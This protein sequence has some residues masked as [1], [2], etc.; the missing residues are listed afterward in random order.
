[1][2]KSNLIR[3]NGKR[4][5][6]GAED[7][8]Y[9]GLDVHKKS[10]NVAVRLGGQ[11]V[12]EWI[13]RSAPAAVISSLQP[14][15]KAAEKVV[16]EAGPCGYGLYRK[17]RE[18]RF[19]AEVWPPGK[20]P[21]K[22]NPGNKTDRLDASTLAE[23]GEKDL[24]E[25][26]VVPTRT[27]EAHR[28][29]MRTRNQIME[30]QKRV[31]QQIKSFLLMHGIEEPEGLKHWSKKG[32]RQLMELELTGELQMCLQMHLE[33]LAQVQHAKKQITDKL[34]CMSRSERYRQDFEN[35]TTHPGV[36]L[37]TA[38]NFILELY[39]PERFEVHRQVSTMLGLVPRFA[40]S[41]ERQTDKG[42]IGAGRESLRSMLVDAAW[43]WVGREQAASKTFGRLVGNTGCK[44]KGIVGIARKLCVN[45]W[46]MLTRR[47]PYRPGG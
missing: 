45:L 3:R 16:Y 38:M 10:T 6:I 23:Y 41:G 39:Q 7:Q 30:K 29:V 9:I 44:Q 13:S 32:V 2:T 46:C 4:I 31:K 17:L 37:L 34:R 28:Q 5:V 42:L 35:L 24:V 18:A 19:P 1:M 8:A 40:S 27:E 15:R 21:R 47:E 11:K 14:L 36:G 33:M 22:A 43:Q 12:A 26:M 25:P 20:I